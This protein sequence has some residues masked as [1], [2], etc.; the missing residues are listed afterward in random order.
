MSFAV[1]PGFYK[2][3]HCRDFSVTPKHSSKVIVEQATNLLTLRP[4]FEFRLNNNNMV[5]LAD[6]NYVSPWWRETKRGP[7][8]HRGMANLVAFGATP[9]D[10]ALPAITRAIITIDENLGLTD[11]LK[12][13]LQTR[14]MIEP[15]E[16]FGI[17]YYGITDEHVR[18]SNWFAVAWDNIALHF[19]HTGWCSVFE[20][21]RG[22]YGATPSFKHAF[23]F[24]KA[25]ETLGRHGMF[26]F[27]PVPGVGLVVQHLARMKAFNLVQRRGGMPWYTTGDAAVVPWTTQVLPSSVW[28][29]FNASS[30]ILA[31][32]PYQKHELFIERVTFDSSG[33]FVDG[34]HET[35][36]KRTALPS[37]REPLILPTWQGNWTGPSPNA[38]V[39][40]RNAKDTADWQTSD[41]RQFRVKVALST[42]NPK[43]TPFVAGYGITWEPVFA[44]R[45]TTEITVSKLLE[46]DFVR[47]ERWRFDGHA[48]VRME[49]AAEKAIAERGDATFKLEWSSDGVSGWSVYEGGYAVEMDFTPH[50]DGK[51]QHY[52]TTM[53]LKSL[54]HRF[55]ETHVHLETSLEAN[56]IKDAITA[57]LK[58]NGFQ[59]LTGS[60]PTEIANDQLPPWEVLSHLKIGPRQGDSTERFLDFLLLL[61]R[62]QYLEFLIR[63]DW[64]TA[65]WVVEKKSRFTAAPNIWHAVPFTDSAAR[66]PHSPNLHAGLSNRHVG[67]GEGT[68]IKP[69]PPEC[70]LLGVEGMT[71]PEGGG[72]RILAPIV[73]NDSLT[74][75]ASP[76][77]LGRPRYVKVE[78]PAQATQGE[79]NKLA[80]RLEPIVMHRRLRGAIVLPP[81]KNNH[82]KAIFMG[83]NLLV[84]H[85]RHDGSVLADLWVKKF[86]VKI[87]V[88]GALGFT[89]TVTL[90]V[91]SV[92][93][94]EIG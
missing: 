32:N 90:H 34:I 57:T 56:Y 58:A 26:W 78:A 76:D 86:G 84:K 28:S 82:N 3:A 71:N 9:T 47:D 62:K 72:H 10:I 91:D 5:P 14:F 70:N 81:H 79:V 87:D 68:T 49:T 6:F 53:A 35:P 64:G 44:N 8:N 92:W 42:T 61:A 31:V 93:E 25:G 36:E 37:R 27:L 48:T 65:S 85:Y 24:G 17:H 73:N 63:Y 18:K 75:T 38:V 77:Y 45:N 50:I 39:S 74:N 20:Y 30:V 46:L 1:E 59:G 19:S 51:G 69:Q 41:G 94:G 22:N 23:Q 2:A 7:D 60:I 89:E 54:S 11:T 67:Y 43:Y 52:V 66:S 88:G 4:S 21:D 15:D 33:H 40:L 12:W 80:R 83:P 16:S 55:T 13:A 29:L